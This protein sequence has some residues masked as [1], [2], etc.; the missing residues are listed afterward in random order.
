MEFFNS[1][2]RKQDLD[3]N[4]NEEENSDNDNNESYYKIQ[5][6]PFNDY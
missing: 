2:I 5:K 6:S 3:N 4:N 1:F